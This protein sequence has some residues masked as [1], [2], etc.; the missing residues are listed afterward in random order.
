MSWN[1]ILILASTS[2]G[3]CCLG[4]KIG[5]S[6]RN[7]KPGNRC[8]SACSSFGW[9]YLKKISQF[10]VGMLNSFLKT[11][12]PLVFLDHSS[13]SLFVLGWRTHKQSIVE[14]THVT[15][16]SISSIYCET[17]VAVGRGIGRVIGLGLQLD[18]QAL[19][20]LQP[21]RD[22]TCVFPFVSG[23]RQLCVFDYSC[24][25]F[26]WALTPDINSSWWR[27]LS[28]TTRR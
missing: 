21:A 18:R 5:R 3:H 28:R 6:S 2:K 14:R 11:Y 17:W 23:G 1:Q 20:F 22:L 8:L 15:L 7:G 10:G 9:Q 12:H 26:Y 27:P 19:P 24:S 16:C 25:L 13:C 4:Q